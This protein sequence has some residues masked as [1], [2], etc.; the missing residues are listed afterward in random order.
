[1]RS[2][3]I[4]AGLKMT[5]VNDTIYF[6]FGSSPLVHRRK[7]LFTGYLRVQEKMILAHYYQ[8]LPLI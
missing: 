4:K 2:G 8:D 3:T 5:Q 1:M 7:G 6:D